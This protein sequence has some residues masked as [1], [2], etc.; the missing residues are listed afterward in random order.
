MTQKANVTD[1][2]DKFPGG[3]A[4]PNRYMVEIQMPAGVGNTGSWM[5]RQALVGAITSHGMLLNNQG[6]V[7]IACHTIS[8]PPRASMVYPHNQLSAQFMVPY[9]QMYEPVTLSFYNSAELNQ[10]TF[11]EIWQSAVFNINDNSMNFFVE[12]ARDM[13]IYQLDRQ[14]NKTYG[15]TLYA[16]WPQSIGDVAYSYSSN[17]TP[18]SCSVTMAYRLWKRTEGPRPDTTDIYTELGKG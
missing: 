18:L 5:N 4:R 13:K 9:S 3:F 1:F 10:R 15:V 7:Q 14:G 8:M 17:N 2:L 16:A 11:F 6:S 12:Y